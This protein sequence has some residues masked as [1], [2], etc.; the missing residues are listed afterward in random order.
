[1]LE[2]VIPIL[3]SE[4]VTLQNLDDVLLPLIPMNKS[5]SS[6]SPEDRQY[7]VDLSRLEYLKLTDAVNLL[8]LIGYLETGNGPK[9]LL[10]PPRAERPNEFL[11]AM[12]FF[13]LAENHC[14]ITNANVIPQPVDVKEKKILEIKH[15]P[16]Q[17]TDTGFAN[18]L[19][20]NTTNTIIDKLTM[21]ADDELGG[22][23]ASAFMELCENVHE[24]SRS[25][26][27]IAAQVVEPRDPD[28]P[29]QFQLTIGDLGIGL[30][31][32]LRGFHDEEIRGFERAYGPLWDEMKAL[33]I[34][35]T[36]GVSF[37]AKRAFDVEARGI[38]LWSVFQTVKEFGGSLICRTG[39][40]KVFLGYWHGQWETRRKTALCFFPGTQLEVRIPLKRE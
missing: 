5:Q 13:V 38:G 9:V 21:L 16:S 17:L 7:I 26:G 22:L 25:Y 2:L 27:Y 33:D 24:H 31:E 3:K 37:K 12:R 40:N 35:F 19:S 10:I 14:L 1:M 34:A 36:P 15:I 11:S 28:S 18:W 39:R 8:L 20:K 6:P 29:E 4:D 30:Y 23:L 32:G